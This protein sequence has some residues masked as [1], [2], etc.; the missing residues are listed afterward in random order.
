MN[1]LRERICLMSSSGSGPEIHAARM[2]I[3][4]IA[5]ITHIMRD[6]TTE[7]TGK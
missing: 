5:P 3:S 7:R 6:V 4:W 1:S 2:R